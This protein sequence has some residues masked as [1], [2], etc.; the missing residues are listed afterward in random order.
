[1]RSAIRRPAPI[2]TFLVPE[3][4]TIESFAIAND[5]VPEAIRRAVKSGVEKGSGKDGR[6]AGVL[7]A[8]TEVAV[9]ELAGAETTLVQ[10]AQVKDATAVDAR[11]ALADVKQLTGRLADARKDLEQLAKER[12]D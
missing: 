2:A 9:G 6:A 12:P 1:M 8:G 11:L 5:V 4:S 10:V 7:V 3:P